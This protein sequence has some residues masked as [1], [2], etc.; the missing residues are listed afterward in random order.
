[1]SFVSAVMTAADFFTPPQLV[2]RARYL[3]RLGYDSM[4]IADIFGREIYV[5]AGF[6]L[7]NTE[8]LK[9]ATGIA[10]IYGRDPIA[11]AQA[12]LTLSELYDGRF[13]QGLG[14][15]H[16]SGAALR[17]VDWEDPSTKARTYLTALRGE[18][19]I[20]RVGSPAPVPLF[21]AA[22]GPKMLA[23]AAEVADGANVY[24]QTPERCAEARAILGPDKTLNLLL[25]MCLTDNPDEGRAA[26]RRA[27][28]VYL[29]LP[30]YHRG[31]RRSG[32]DES[33][34]SGG[35][36]D[37]LVDANVAW[38]SMATI[39]SRLREFRDAGVDHVIIAAN[40]A[41]GRPESANELVE[42]LAPER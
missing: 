20:R 37:R 7:A 25:P 13:I 38:G 9:V 40:A 16:P 32:F 6:V 12:A 42:A 18:L 4:W 8:T 29:P 34:W 33:D 1:M 11:S 28:G 10:H 21:L 23:V 31:W 39:E 3:E 24:M 30:A 17:G 14:L 22:H 27:L 5:T 15:S 35:G 2:D 26:G 19:P 41:P 36:S